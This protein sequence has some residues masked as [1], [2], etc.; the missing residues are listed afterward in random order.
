[1]DIP[2][3]GEFSIFLAKSLNQRNLVETI[4]SD[5]DYM[6]GVI[7][8]HFNGDASQ[9][10]MQCTNDSLSLRGISQR[11]GVL[12]SGIAISTCYTILRL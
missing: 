3:V 12:S 6:A 4:K 8:G 2:D 5:G 10:D 11:N 7:W 9:S 1:M